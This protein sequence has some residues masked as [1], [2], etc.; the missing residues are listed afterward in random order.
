MYG[1]YQPDTSTFTRYY[2]S[3]RGRP[4]PANQSYTI[5]PS[6]ITPALWWGNGIVGAASRHFPHPK[7]WKVRGPDCYLDEVTVKLLTLAY[8]LPKQVPPSCIKAW[9]ARL[10]VIPWDIIGRK[11]REKLLT[12]K[13]FM[14]HFKLILHRAL[15]TR[16][17]NPDHINKLTTKCRLCGKTTEKIEHLANCTALEPIWKKF[18]SLIGRHPSYP[19]DIARLLLLGLANPPLLQSHSDFHLILWKFILI[20]FTLVDVRHKPFRH[21]SVWKGAVRRYASKANKLTHSILLKQKHCET[22]L[23]DQPDPA[24]IGKPIDPLG[25]LRHD[26]TI[27][28]CLAI[29]KAI[30]DDA[31]T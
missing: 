11:Y 1:T 12:P 7:G 9:E 18:C 30:A 20:H 16:H 27:K 4:Y 19:N 26:G 2:I 21:E 23:H 3:T 8:S 15:Y 10:G 22:C 14:T 5:P 24:I 29:T 25:A 17:I 13:D 31:P 6:N 28:W